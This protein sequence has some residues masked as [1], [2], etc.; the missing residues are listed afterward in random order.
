LLHNQTQDKHPFED[1][2]KA[3]GNS[4]ELNSTTGLMPSIDAF[5]TE[6]D[7]AAG[8]ET[9]HP[10]LSCM[11]RKDATHT[12]TDFKDRGEKSKATT[13]EAHHAHAFLM[14]GG[15]CRSPSMLLRTI[16]QSVH[17]HKR[18]PHSAASYE[19]LQ[20]FVQPLAPVARNTAN[21]TI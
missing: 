8:I 16:T 15:R 1:V 11:I 4:T 21:M 12:G 14:G 19:T 20:T 9:V 7:E 17:R 6:A 2:W 3:D 5:V 10:I 18:L 13:I